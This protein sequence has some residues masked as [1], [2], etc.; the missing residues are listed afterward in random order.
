MATTTTL[1]LSD[2]IDEVL[3]L[4]Y[5]D[6][7]RPRRVVVGSNALS[8]G[9]DT[10]FTVS[11]D[12]DDINVGDIVEFDQERT[13]VTAKSADATPIFTVKR[14]FGGDP[15][16]GAVATGDEGNLNPLWPRRKV[17]DAVLRAFRGPLGTYLPLVLN[18]TLTTVS[19]QYY[20]EVPAAALEVIRVGYF[21]TTTGD[22]TGTPV[23]WVELTGWDYVPYLATGA[24]TTT[25][26]LTIPKGLA[27][28]LELEVAYTAHYAWSGGTAS[29]A[30]DE[31]VTIELGAT[32]LPALYVAARLVTGRELTRL[33][34]DRVEEWNHEAAIRNGVNLRVVSALWGDFYRRLDEA[35]RQ[36]RRPKHRTYRKMRRVG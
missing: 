26:L 11:T 31:T 27:A 22:S 25:K 9:S 32:D 3:D 35:R 34:L 18:T 23:E 4:I 24:S 2:I 10:T 30:E 12:A 8:S 6:T 15:T 14:A 20:L 13:L 29:P 1:T 21:A 17:K 19:N 36:E 28:G 7:E 16:A 33:E 5:R